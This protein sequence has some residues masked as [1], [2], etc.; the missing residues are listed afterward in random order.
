MRSVVLE[1]VKVAV[2]ADDVFPLSSD[3]NKLV[4][5]KELQGSVAAVVK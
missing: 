4:A 3:H 2:F 1:T 5:E